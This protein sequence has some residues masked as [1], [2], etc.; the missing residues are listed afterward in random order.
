MIV[1]LSS[2]KKV[3]I[4]IHQGGIFSDKDK[5][6]KT[7]VNVNYTPH[8]YGAQKLTETAVIESCYKSLEN[9]WKLKWK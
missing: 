1:Q 6:Q 3:A 7:N 4:F 2:P 5:K 8:K 9:E